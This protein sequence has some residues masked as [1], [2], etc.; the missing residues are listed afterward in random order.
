MLDDGKR[1]AMERLVRRLAFQ[2]KYM[3]VGCSCMSGCPA[4]SWKGYAAYIQVF[5]GCC[6]AA[7]GCP[8]YAVRCPQSQACAPIRPACL[9]REA[10]IVYVGRDKVKGVPHHAKAGNI[11]SC[12]LKEGACKVGCPAG[13]GGR[14]GS[15]GLHVLPV[16]GWVW[17]LGI[18]PVG[19]GRFG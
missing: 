2:C 6:N 19:A 10:T 11:N 15:L 5:W 14:C 12:L 9:Q 16:G 17:H 13:S 1:P 7:P 18:A 8:A 4:F 3:Q